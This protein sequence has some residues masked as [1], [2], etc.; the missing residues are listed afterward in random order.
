MQSLQH[1]ADSLSVAIES[2]VT[3][4]DLRFNALIEETNVCV[5]VKSKAGNLTLANRVYNEVFAGGDS[6]LGKSGYDLLDASVQ[7][8]SRH[9]DGLVLGGCRELIM[10]HFGIAHGTSK[11]T[12]RTLKRS[13]GHL[14]HDG[15]AILGL[16]K[17]VAITSQLEQDFSL[18][19]IKRRFDL[20]ADIDKKI[21]IHISAGSSPKEVAE[22][23]DICSRTVVNRRKQIFEKLKISNAME[24]ACMLYSLQ[25][26]AGYEFGLPQYGGDVPMRHI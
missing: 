18:R 9:S 15:F 4:T 24:M 17:V 6:S 16:T 21:A 26:Q 22:M 19:E 8:V 5:Y 11:C 3:Q 14:H 12:F 25:L 7:E 23:L 10:E 1:L 13:L 2:Y 20:L